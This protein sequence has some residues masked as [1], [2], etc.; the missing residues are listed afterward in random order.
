MIYLSLF[1]IIYHQEHLYTSYALLLIYISHIIKQ[2]IADIPL[3]T[4]E[5]SKSPI[6]I[7]K[8]LLYQL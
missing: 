1:I 5:N 4:Q 8:I 2:T 7:P 3:D 6:L